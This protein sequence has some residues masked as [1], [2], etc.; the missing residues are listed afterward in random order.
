[1]SLAAGALLLSLGA[2]AL[3]EVHVKGKVQI[4]NPLTA[5][6]EPLK[7]ARVRVVL[8]EDY[9]GDTLDKEDNTDAYGSYSIS[10][11]NPW[12]YNA[13]KCYVIVYA[14]VPNRLEVQSVYGQIDGYQAFTA[15]T[16]AHQNATTT[17]DVNIGAPGKTNVAS[18]H[19]GGLAAFGD[20]D[21][22]SAS[23]GYHAFL[24]CNEMTK[25]R[26]WLQEQAFNGDQF[27]EKEV[28]YPAGDGADY[29]MPW[30]YI[31]IPESKF[32]D[33]AASGDWIQPYGT[34]R[35]ELTHGLMADEYWC[36]L[37]TAGTHSYD[38]PCD[39]LEGA[40]SEG[41]ADFL[42]QT[43]L[44][45][46]YG[47]TK[48]AVEP[49]PEDVLPYTPTPENARIEGQIAGAMWDIY[50]PVGWEKRAHQIPAIPG[51]EMFY[52][53]IDDPQLSKIKSIFSADHPMSFTDGTFAGGPDSFIHYWLGRSAYD[54]M[55]HAL[56][57]ILLNR[58]IKSGHFTQV[59]PHIA[60]GTPTWDKCTVKLPFTV[61]ESDVEDRGHVW[62]ELSS[63]SAGLL[64][65]QLL[66]DG[67]SGAS[68]S[69]TFEHGIAWQPG[70][71]PPVL[72]VAANDDVDSDYVTRTLTVPPGSEAGGL[73]VEVTGLTIRREPIGDNPKWEPDFWPSN[74]EKLSGV[75]AKITVDDGKVPTP[76]VTQLVNT[77][78]INIG[79]RTRD[80]LKADGWAGGTGEVYKQQN[81]G[82]CL[83][84]TLEGGFRQGTPQFTA[85]A[86][87]I[88]HTR[89]LNYGIGTHTAIIVA[90]H[91][92]PSAAQAGL[93]LRNVME[94]SY[95]VSPLR[96]VTPEPAWPNA[97][98]T[99]PSPIPSGLITMAQPSLAGATLAVAQ[100]APLTLS[101]M[102]SR[103]SRL[104][105]EYARL[106]GLLHEAAQVMEYRL[107]PRQV[108][109]T[110]GVAAPGAAVQSAQTVQAAQMAQLAQGVAP[111][112]LRQLKL[113][114][115]LQGVM[116]GTVR[117]P[118]LT[119]AQRAEM[120]ALNAAL[121]AADERL[122]VIE[123]EGA[124]LQQRLTAGIARLDTAPGLSAADR[125]HARQVLAS[126]G[127]RVG[128][129][130][131]DV[132]KTRAFAGVERQLMG[133]LRG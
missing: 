87:T 8:W 99:Q 74:V 71:P 61:T 58:G 24:I 126:A 132:A 2:P 14:E 66:A 57:A 112:Q 11:G 125:T 104:A 91:A 41:W 42:P 130:R 22:A 65:R 96:P 83:R 133:K 54:E 23:R 119:P 90:D 85:T 6:Y 1:M 45:A 69:G 127:E 94:I 21:S 121:V 111:L 63:S 77:A 80:V 29:R 13:Y 118:V 124:A 120:D 73:L 64:Q 18:W 97:I 16:S 34:F 55:K 72:C 115:S 49:S 51:D 114:A 43:S 38:S 37:E 123:T 102:L 129:V 109:P 20:Y 67:W 128:Q 70:F 68:C 32:T 106:Q 98:A 40:W 17:I 30:D 19:V 84:L 86:Q 95:R 89:D 26:L 35:H 60:V 15:R 48:H 116:A 12:W 10:K 46:N 92:F 53:G 4:Y 47:S 52:D 78:Q 33:V 31:R 75:W 122:P 9:D 3:A 117:L 131:A 101:A 5:A 50:D 76:R 113:P 81:L 39:T 105:D 93:S 59:A 7:Q 103:A 28:S 56:K 25:H 82:T 108:A 36:I 88:E 62:A 107:G 100:L 27:E 110:T 79:T 44:L